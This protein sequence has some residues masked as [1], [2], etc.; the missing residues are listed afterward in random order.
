MSNSETCWKCGKVWRG[1][2][3]ILLN[4]YS[5]NPKGPECKSVYQCAIRVEERKKVETKQ[6]IP[7]MPIH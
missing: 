5:M 3:P 2:L 6:Y 1:D 4:V 7:V